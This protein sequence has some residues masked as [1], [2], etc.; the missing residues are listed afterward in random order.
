MRRILFH[1]ARPWECGAH[2]FPDT[3]GRGQRDSVSL[4][5]DTSAPAAAP[6]PVAAES[7]S[8]RRRRRSCSTPRWPAPRKSGK[9]Q[10]E[11]W[12]GVDPTRR[13][14][15][16]HSRVS[17]SQGLVHQ[18]GENVKVVSPNCR[19]RVERFQGGRGPQHL[20]RPLPFPGLLLAHCPGSLA[21]GRRQ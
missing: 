12:V 11:R 15:C 19:L 18:G 4:E 16:Y 13:W 17:R 14:A 8:H 20:Q 1:T 6:G 7:P 21:R 3:G 5:P 10:M 2:P 9:F